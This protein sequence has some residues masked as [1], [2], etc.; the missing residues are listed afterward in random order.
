MAF[1]KRQEH[2]RAYVL[3]IKRQ[4][5]VVVPICGKLTPKV[6]ATEFPSRASAEAWLCSDEGGREIDAYRN[7]SALRLQRANLRTSLRSDTIAFEGR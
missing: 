5:R 3:Q 2:S 6:H 7:P 4:W 1:M